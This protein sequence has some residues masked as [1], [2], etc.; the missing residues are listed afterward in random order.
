MTAPGFLIIQE[1]FF[2]SD[3]R[4]IQPVFSE[5]HPDFPWRF[6]RAVLVE[7]TSPRRRL[8]CRKRSHA[9]Q[10]VT[11]W[12]LTA[13]TLLFAEQSTAARAVCAPSRQRPF[14]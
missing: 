11:D 3:C 14:F 5:K 1:P 6:L 4:P 7:M 12:R 9:V 2:L 10:R 8:E 13:I